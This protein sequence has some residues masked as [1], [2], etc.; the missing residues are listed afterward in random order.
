MPRANRHFLPGHAW[1]IT[2]RCHKKE[3]LLKFAKDRACWVH[4]LFEAKKRFGL[5]VLNYIVTS[6]HIHLVVYDTGGDVIPKSMQLIAGRT[7]QA[8]NQRKQ[9]K[10]AFWEDRYHAT[11]IETDDHLWRC[12]VYIDLN[13]VRAGVV[14]HPSEWPHSGYHGIQSPPLRKSVIDLPQLL[15]LC[16][17]DTLPAFQRAH[18][19]WIADALASGS[20][21]RDA[22][23]SEAIALGS[24]TF[25]EEVYAELGVRARGRTVSQQGD[26]YVIKESPAMYQTHLTT[27]K[28]QLGLENRVFWDK[29]TCN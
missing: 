24:Q 12:L 10:G 5:C 8:Y 25:V 23:W 16:N 7:A 14:T 3:F 18:E 27:E 4:W 1:H 2:H 9:R 11:A 28:L 19:G 6:N 17:V 21:R 20:A 29:N 13:M 26:S 15:E 22:L